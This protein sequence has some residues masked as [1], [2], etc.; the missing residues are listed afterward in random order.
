MEYEQTRAD[1]PVGSTAQY[2]S[3]QEVEIVSISETEQESYE[4]PTQVF[5]R[6]NGLI[7]STDVSK[8]E[9]VD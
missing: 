3:G 8:L 7:Q 4:N 6:M 9:K 5:V 1:F 2:P